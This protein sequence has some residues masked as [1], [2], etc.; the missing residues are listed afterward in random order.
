[1]LPADFLFSLCARSPC[2][3]A[4]S[5]WQDV[6]LQLQ[7]DFPED[8]PTSPPAVRFVTPVFHPNGQQLAGTS[9]RAGSFVNVL[10]VVLFDLLLSVRCVPVDLQ[11]GAVCASVLS[12]G[13][14]SP[15][16]TLHP[17]LLNLQSLLLEPNTVS[18]SNPEAA[19]LFVHEPQEKFWAHVYHT[20]TRNMRDGH[21][22]S[23]ALQL[24]PRSHA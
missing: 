23:A 8:Y 11:S 13:E 2:S 5:D 19:P 4:H 6:T 17:L 10:T 9:D 12:A 16:Y 15:S 24:P 3:A 22:A 21:H 1:M 14:W 18:P 7:I 20:H